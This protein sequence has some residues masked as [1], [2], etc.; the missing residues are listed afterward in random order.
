MYY[1]NLVCSCQFY[2]R[3]M[4]PLPQKNQLSV[5]I[6]TNIHLNRIFVQTHTVEAPETG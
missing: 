2:D 3:N 1:H 5:K 4:T 6:V